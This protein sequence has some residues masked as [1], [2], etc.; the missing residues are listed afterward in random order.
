MSKIV[1]SEEVSMDEDQLQAIVNVLNEHAL[2]PDD[3]K[4]TLDEVVNNRELLG[5]ICDV[6]ADDEV[7]FY[8]P[9]KCF[10]NGGWHLWRSFRNMT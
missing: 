3:L 5:Y 10:V 2:G 8:N 7:A 9:L 1:W 4:L 6:A